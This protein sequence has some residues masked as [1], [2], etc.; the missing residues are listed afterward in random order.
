ML[1][2]LEFQ[3]GKASPKSVTNKIYCL[4]CRTKVNVK[5]AHEVEMKNGRRRIAAKCSDCGAG[6]SKIIAGKK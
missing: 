3:G 5:D 6:V 2:E 1:N 4:R